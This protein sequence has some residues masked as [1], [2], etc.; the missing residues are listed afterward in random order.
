MGKFGGRWNKRYWLP[1]SSIGVDPAEWA[2][3]PAVHVSFS[4][5]RDGAMFN[6]I[7][8]LRQLQHEGDT[9]EFSHVVLLVNTISVA[10]VL[11]VSVFRF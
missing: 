5:G 6:T 10:D 2:K 8:E 11:R 9:R 7:Q 3:L 1:L 4:L